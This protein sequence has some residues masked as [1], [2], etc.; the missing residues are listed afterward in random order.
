MD[1]YASRV[2]GLGAPGDMGRAQNALELTYELRSSAM[3]EIA[4][5][6]STALGD[7]GSAKATAAIA[8]QM[9]KLLATDVLYASVVRPEIDGVL[10]DNGIEGSDVPESVFLPDG[11]K[12]LDESTVSSAL[13]SG[14]RLQRRRHAGRARARTDRRQHQRDR[15][16]RRS[17][18]RSRPKKRSKS[19]STVQNQGESTE[20]GVGVTVSVRRH[21]SCRDSIESIGA[22]E[23]ATVT[24][25]LTP[26]P[27][28]EVTLEVKVDTGPR[29]ADHRKQR[30]QLHR[31][32]RIGRLATRLAPMRIAY[33]GPAGTF[34]EDALGEATAR[35]RVRAAAHGD[36][37][38]RDPRRRARR[39][40]ARPGPL[41]EL[42]RGLGPRHPRH[43]RLRGRG[44][45][46]RRRA[47]LR[48][49]RPPDRPR[50]GRAGRD[51]GR[52]LPP[53]AAGP[54]RPL[55]ARAAARGRTAQRQQHR[56]GGADGRR[57]GPALGGDRVP[58]RGRALRLRRS[59]ARGSRTRPTTSP[60]S[61]GS[62]RPGPTPARAS[63]WK[64]S[65]VFSELGEDHPGALVDAL[66]S[67]PTRAINLTRIESRPLRQGL[68]RYMFFCDL[69][70]AR[71][72][73]GRRRGDR[74]AAGKG[75]V[76]ADPRLLSRSG[77]ATDFARFPAP[78]AVPPTICAAH[79]TGSGAQRDV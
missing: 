66:A 68:G 79:G 2:D 22:G 65:L 16:G 29:R 41:R 25:P 14:Q 69:E 45:D 31:R 11:T 75:R 72:R 51:R 10:A 74:R 52:A 13:G 4:D 76:G 33:L 57:V 38:R 23:T 26:T 70:G 21:R 50:G 49:A 39:G 47:R 42:D 27:S 9:Q 59:S 62:P 71:G 36:D 6:M 56:G 48:G 55:P 64:T 77:S 44:G 53:A 19:K 46:D 78:G 15:T 8:R 63:A 32:L 58:R 28:G 34:T 18:R 37:P 30:S 73:R 61:S 54:V 60:A 24:I 5:K 1:N 12:W 67:S 35:R 7:A 17:G 3:T 43:P 20:N 40:R